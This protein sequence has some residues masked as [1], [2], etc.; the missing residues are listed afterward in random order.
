MKMASVG[1]GA[2]AVAAA[3]L[4]ADAAAET[5]KA[6]DSTD[7]AFQAVYVLKYAEFGSFPNY[8]AY[9]MGEP[10]YSNQPPLNYYMMYWLIK[11]KDR[12]ILVLVQV[13][14]LPRDTRSTSHLM[15]CW[16]R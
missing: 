5:K 14:T 10:L 13:P 11:T 1:I 7:P 2:G 3:G 15:R 6:A 16:P 4:A 9:W 8:L 12:N